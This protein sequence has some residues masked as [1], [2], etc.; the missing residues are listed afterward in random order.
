M[1]EEEKSSEEKV[2]V[3]L[4]VQELHVSLAEIFDRWSKIKTEV[5]EDGEVPSR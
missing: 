5:K 4:E 2:D 1:I 3:V